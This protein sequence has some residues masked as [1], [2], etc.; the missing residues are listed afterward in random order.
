MIGYQAD[1]GEKY[2]G[3]LY[4]ESRRNKILARPTRS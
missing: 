3:A 1:L 4:D 2:Y